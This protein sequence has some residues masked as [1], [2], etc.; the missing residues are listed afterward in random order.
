M[1][2][3]AVFASYSYYAKGGWGDFC[4]A[5]DDEVQAVNAARSIIKDDDGDWA[6]V[7]DLQDGTVI[8]S[9]EGDYCGN[10]RSKDG[11]R[12]TEEEAA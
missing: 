5:Y 12:I 11:R 3:Y 4:G 6:H 9:D 7:V 2:R 10:V 1:K 8:A